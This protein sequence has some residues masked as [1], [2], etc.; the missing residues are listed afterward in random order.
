MGFYAVFIKNADGV[1]E[2]YD[3]WLNA[4]KDHS[5]IERT[6]MALGKDPQDVKVVWYLAPM[7]LDN[8]AIDANMNLVAHDMI[9]SVKEEDGVDDQGKPIK[10]QT[11]IKVFK[12]KKQ[13]APEVWW[14]NGQLKKNYE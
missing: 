12:A 7:S 1:F 10:K 8:P 3:R 13:Y 11:P 5:W 14:E 9:D 6:I 4:R 2:Y